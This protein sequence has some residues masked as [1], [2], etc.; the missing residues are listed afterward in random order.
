MA[1]QNQNSNQKEQKRANKILELFSRIQHYPYSLSDEDFQKIEKAIVRKY[2]NGDE[3]TKGMILF[4]INEKLS[5]VGNIREFINTKTTKAPQSKILGDALNFYHSLDGQFFLL[6]LLK[7]FGDDLSL[8]LLT[9]FTS[10]YLSQ[11]AR[12][13]HIFAEKCIDLLGESKNVY[14]LKFLISLSELSSLDS[15]IHDVVL[16]NLSNWKKKIPR[17][18]IDGKEKKRL[19]EKLDSLTEAPT[20]PDYYS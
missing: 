16:H 20:S 13:Y 15:S 12:F 8:K 14:A 1:T 3:K 6:S 18:K 9:H 5:D 17:L 4:F 7:K 10:K 11:P 2:K 19:K